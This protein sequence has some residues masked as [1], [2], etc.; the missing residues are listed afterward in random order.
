MATKITVQKD[1]VT[2]TIDAKK[3]KDYVK[4]GWVVVTTN[5]IPNYIRTP[6]NTK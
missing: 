6:Y 5:S 1:G 2:K 4:N 3:E